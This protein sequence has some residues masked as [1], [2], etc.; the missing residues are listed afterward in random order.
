MPRPIHF[1]MVADDPK[2]AMKFYETVFGWKFQR[3][4]RAK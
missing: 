3:D 2:T 4:K 1:D